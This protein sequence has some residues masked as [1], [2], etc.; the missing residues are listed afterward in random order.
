MKLTKVIQL[1]IVKPENDG[2]HG[3]LVAHVSLL[4][5][6]KYHIDSFTLAS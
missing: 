6:L 3:L 1:E 5:V 2:W 4:R